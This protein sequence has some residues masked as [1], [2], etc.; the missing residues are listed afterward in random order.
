MKR[1]LKLTSQLIDDFYDV[2]FKQIPQENNLAADEVSKLASNEDAPER[3]G[4]YMEV[5]TIP[6]I[7]GLQAFSVQQ[8]ST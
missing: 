5:L 3:T 2:R 7:E 6:S 4:L 1:H 8:S